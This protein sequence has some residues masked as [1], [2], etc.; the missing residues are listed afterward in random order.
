MVDIPTAGTG[1]IFVD[2]Y[3]GDTT[4]PVDVLSL[5]SGGDVL[6][7][8]TPATGGWVDT[9]VYSASVAITAAASPYTRLYD[10]WYDDTA[11]YHTGTIF[12]KTLDSI[13]WNP[14]P[15]HVTNIT[16]LRQ[17]YSPNETSVR[18]RIY[19][20]EKD[21]SP[22]I[23]TVASKTIENTSIENSYYKVYRIIDDVE[24]V[25]FATG[26]STTPQA[27]GNVESYSRLSYDVSGNYFDFNMNMLEPGYSYGVKL[28][29]FINSSWQEQPEIFKFRVE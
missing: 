25:K 7:A 17:R 29:Y 22:T 4:A 14:N 19:A 1:N 2:L 13:V 11:Q 8:N 16:N 24:V 28:A 15:N 23:Y 5:S 26:S 21:W 27:L 9:G 10:V 20:R 12:P 18:F 6:T 3:A